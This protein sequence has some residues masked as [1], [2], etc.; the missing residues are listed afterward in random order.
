M[1]ASFVV[2]SAVALVGAGTGLLTR[3][4]RDAHGPG[5]L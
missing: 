3:Q 4:G 1:S 2:A 5:M